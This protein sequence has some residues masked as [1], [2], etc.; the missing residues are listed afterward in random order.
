VTRQSIAR[1]ALLGALILSLSVSAPPAFGQ[2]NKAEIVGT[3][4]DVSGALIWH[5]T[6]TITNVNTAAERSVTTSEEGVYH[7]PLLEIGVYKVS[8]TGPN[9]NTAVRENV[10]LQTGDRLAVNFVLVPGKVQ[11][12]VVINDAPPQ[13]K[14]ESSD[15]GSVV[16]GREINE[17]PL[18]GRNFTQ[19]ATLTPGVVRSVNVSSTAEAAVF[20]NGDPRAGN[21]GPG[22]G[23]AAGGPQTVRFSRS[24]GASLSVNGQ[25]PTNN[26]FSLD[27]VD[28]NEP[29][30]GTIGIYPNPDAMAEFKVTTSIPPAE[31]GRAGGAVVSASIKSGTNEF[32]GSLFYYGQNGA[33][34]AYHPILKRQRAEAIAGGDLFIP[35]KPVL[36][37]HEFGGVVGGPII[38]NRTF[39]FFDYLGQRNNLPIPFDTTVPT[40]LSR[41]GDFSEFSGQIL[42]P[43]T[44]QSFPGNIIPPGRLDPV[45]L[46]YQNLFPLPTRSLRDPGKD[47][48]P[49]T[50]SNFFSVRSNHEEINNY[51]M[52]MD[53]RL[54]EKNSLAGRYSFQNTVRHR[55]NF[56]AKLPTAGFGSGD[57]FGN[58]RQIALSDTHAFSPTVLNEFRFGLT[59]IDISIFN[60]GVGGAC[61]VSPTFASDIGIP[62][63][64]DGAL[65]G[66]GGPVIGNF[67][68][69]VQET[70]GDGGLFQVRSKNP[71]FA[72]SL[73]LIKSRH[74]T[75]FGSE[76]RLRYVQTVD[77]GRAGLLKG[78]LIFSDTWPISNPLA[79]GQVCPPESQDAGGSRCFVNPNGFPYGGTGN[80]QANLLIGAGAILAIHGRIFGGPFHLRSQ[81]YALFAQDDWKV[82]ERLTLDIGLRYDLFTPPAERDR[83][84]GNYD[85]VSRQVIIA[86]DR[87]IRMDRNNL[88]PRFGFAYGIGREKALVL[89]G[90]YGLLYT[91]D[92]LD[93]PPEIQNPPFSSSVFLLSNVF[94]NDPVTSLLT[95][96][97][98]TGPP[99]VAI[100]TDPVDL[101]PDVAV[102]YA[103]PRQK[104]ASV[105]QFQLSFQWQLARDYSLDVGYVGNRAR[106][107]LATRNIDSTGSAEARN[108]EGQFLNSA[109]A[110]E[111]RASSNYD[112]LQVQLQRRLSGNV[113]GQI[114][115]TWSH[116]IDDSTGVFQS[117][118]D[119]RG[120]RGGPANP[121]N[122]RLD[123]GNSSLDVRHLLSANAIIDLPFGKGQ[124]FLNLKGAV[125]K[126]VSGLQ[127][128]VIVS[129]RSGFPFTVTSNEINIG[130]GGGPF[131]AGGSVRATQIG[132]PFANVPPGRFLNIAAFSSDATCVT[133][134]AG[135]DICFGSLGRNTFRGPA[136]WNTDLS[137]FKN[138]TITDKVKIQLGVEFFDLF[139]YP[140]FT[141]P[142]QNVSDPVSFGRF[143]SA[144]PGRVIQYRLKLL[145]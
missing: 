81:E 32:H 74:V 51:E 105:H 54:S 119:A 42:D 83:R 36:Q 47:C 92:G 126:I 16:T 67:G 130:S 139:N 84:I 53:H 38:K 71:Y 103:E 131:G 65:Q 43:R 104:T 96:N 50:G 107:L 110:F 35:K 27:G 5:A 97:L 46:K 133:N 40:A 95:F 61:G 72:D 48:F 8:A 123:R 21:G 78:G 98:Q 144:Y 117:I 30:F 108:R 137:V 109:L 102:F 11:A 56:F 129:G 24:G 26:N 106:N 2:S 29:L 143:D 12:A 15:R 138:T 93:Y 34:N 6:V 37:V 115:Y 10:V 135:N 136:I 17:L 52:K 70:T 88:G 124:R 20:N 14:T 73:T 120:P 122:F 132:D 145:F 91:L 114:S 9:F 45:A 127:V 33:L 31:V 86:S 90:G 62:N 7:A 87:L 128:N 25:R 44:G 19:L 60:C 57:E 140:S 23:S 39:F 41:R 111:N 141:V 76:I 18:S 75:R 112:G 49:C 80:S 63:S 85:L 1:P 100:P 101:S 116:T 89:R 66:S 118:G 28:N 125:G 113:Q 79:A 121:F 142:N 22:G 99:I 69:G 59:N 82:N 3:V 4:T 55:A 68:V 134:A 64:N 58:S 13:I 94:S 77:G